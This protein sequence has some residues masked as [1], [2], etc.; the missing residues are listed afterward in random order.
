MLSSKKNLTDKIL[1]LGILVSLFVSML[2]LGMVAYLLFTIGQVEFGA[3]QMLGQIGEGLDGFLVDDVEYVIQ[4]DQNIP[5]NV[6][7]PVKQELTVPLLA[8]INQEFPLKADIPINTQIVAPI[9]TTIPVNQNFNASI[10]LFGQPLGIPVAING[11]LPVDITLDIPFEHTIIID[12]M[13]PISM[14]ITT[15][16]AVAISQTIPIQASLPLSMTFPVQL[17]MGNSMTDNFLLGLETT[18]QGMETNGQRLIMVV[19]ILSGVLAVILVV[20]LVILR[21]Y[22]VS[23]KDA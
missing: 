9:S 5:I 15:V 16:F 6:N 12:T 23:R 8:Q 22:T 14:P 10:I 3:A 13:I 20:V 19:W 18:A 2:S 17:S 1:L 21:L 7:F 4:V 11:N